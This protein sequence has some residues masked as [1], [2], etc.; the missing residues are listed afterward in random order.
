MVFGLEQKDGS[1]NDSHGAGTSCPKA[2]WEISLEICGLDDVFHWCWPIFSIYH[3]HTIYYSCYF[4]CILSNY[5]KVFLRDIHAKIWYCHDGVL[6]D[7]GILS[8]LVSIVYFICMVQ[9]FLYHYIDIGTIRRCALVGS[10]PS[11]SIGMFFGCALFWCWV[12]LCASLTISLIEFYLVMI[13]IMRFVT[14]IG[15]FIT[16]LFILGCTFRLS[17]TKKF[18]FCKCTTPW[19]FPTLD[20]LLEYWIEHVTFGLLFVMFKFP[21]RIFYRGGP[22]FA[23]DCHCA[24]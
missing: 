4:S 2:G 9:D 23:T 7:T 24:V 10:T 5:N 22:G 11:Q 16:I 12:S 20:I 21:I 3:I 18:W 8:C 6:D 15:I 1:F 19:M 17:L 13:F 14:T